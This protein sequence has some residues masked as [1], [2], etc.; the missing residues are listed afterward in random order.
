MYSSLCEK[1]SRP[2]TKTFLFLSQASGQLT[3]KELLNTEHEKTDVRFAQLALNF[4]Q[5]SSQKKAS[6]PR[7]KVFGILGLVNRFGQIFLVPDYRKSVGTVFTEAAKVVINFSKSLKI[8]RYSSRESGLDDR[9]SWAPDWN[10]NT[11]NLTSVL[12]NANNVLQAI[13]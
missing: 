7:D 10:F 4:L 1:P 12:F 11:E 2:S 5:L 6:D 13:Y 9:P 3:T 8:L